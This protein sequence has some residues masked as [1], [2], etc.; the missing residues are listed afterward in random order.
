MLPACQD[1]LDVVNPNEPTLDV[2]NTEEGLKRSMLGIY[3]VFADL[4][5]I[6]LALTHHEV[7]GDALYV[8]WGNFSWRWANQPTSITLDDGTVITP[9]E[10]GTQGEELNARNSR[11]QGDNNAFIHEWDDMY[12][13]NNI[14]N[15]LLQ[16]VDAGTIEL[17]GDA[18]T[19]EATVRAYAH[20][21]KGFVYSR[22]GSLYA[23][24][25]ITDEFAGIAPNDNFVDN[26]AILDEADNQLSMAVAIL[27][28]LEDND[29]YREYMTVGIP[30]YMRVDGVPTP[31]M[32][33]RNANTLRAR[34]IL[35]NSRI[36]DIDDATWNR[37]KSLTENGLEATDRNLEFR[38]AD[39]NAA[40]AAS[41]WTPHRVLIGWAFPSER[42]IQD[43]KDG[44]QRFERNFALLAT[45]NVN[46]RGRGIQYGTRYGFRSIDAGGDYAS[47]TSGLASIAVA[48]NYVE[49]ALMMAE[50]MIQTDDVEGG[51]EIIDAVREIQNAGLN[52]VADDNLDQDDAYEELRK[53]RRVALLLDGVAFYDARRWG[54]IDPV[55]SGGGREGAVVLDAM[56]ILNTNA[57]INYNYLN[58]WAVPAGEIDFNAPSPG[59]A[60]VAAF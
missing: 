52:S 60:S 54:V 35:V 25:I 58:Y 59:S 1:D 48:G 4:N 23:A 8:P 2:L 9:P 14:A 43:F 22:I 42:L 53:E 7:M 51:L 37:I 19:K 6:W 33:A 17:S 12:Q 28:D 29:A 3:D 40:F 50:A 30:D 49:N 46:M 26:Q 20:F 56:G 24:G 11:A 27:D 57:T 39:E 47:T 41:A 45:P 5:Y 38:N 55:S 18:A 36:D 32:L 34:N 44:D 10:G 13:I 15:L 16:Q 31:S 21:W